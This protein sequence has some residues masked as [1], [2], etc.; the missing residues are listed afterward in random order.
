M[1]CETPVNCSEEASLEKRGFD[2]DLQ[3]EIEKEESHRKAVLQSIFDVIL[4]VATQGSPLRGSNETLNF[5]DPRCGKFL[6]TIELVSHYHPPL[7]EHILRH[8]KG[9]VT[10][11]S[12]KIQNEFLK[13]I[14]NKI[15]EQ[16]MEEAE[17]AKYYAVMFD[18]TPD[19]SHL[20][21]MSQ[22]LRYV[23][24]V[25]NVPEIT[26]RLID[27]FI[28]RDKT[29][30]AFSEEILKKIEQEGLDI[31]NCR[32]QSYDNGPNMAGIYQEI[33][34]RISKRNPLAKF[35]PRPA[36]TLDL[37]RVNAATAVYEVAGYCR[38]VNCLYTYFSTST[39]R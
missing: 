19:V 36:Y 13:I 27:F 31:K 23:R 22:V 39:N 32:G 9:Q 11:F 28:V 12:S 30:V 17:E 21:Q 18:C 25:G 14:S 4:H 7:R 24:V 37:V 26:E 2:K 35:V 5:S 20:E 3:D 34:A 29:G 1:S 15:R 6:N 33:Q 38:T 8:T 10:Y 16:I